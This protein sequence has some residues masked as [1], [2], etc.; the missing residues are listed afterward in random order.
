MTQSRPA[1]RLSQ[2]AQQRMTQRRINPWHVIQALSKTP[3]RRMDNTLMYVT[4]RVTVIANPQTAMIVTV[5]KTGVY[6]V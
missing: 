4:Q 2:H 1:Y 3:R 6:H 5:Y